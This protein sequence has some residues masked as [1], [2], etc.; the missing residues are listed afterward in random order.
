[1]FLVLLLSGF[2]SL[3]AAAV[4][5]QF[6]F[7]NEAK[8]WTEAQSYCR[9]HYT[10]LATL[11]N[12]DDVNALT[13]LGSP[14]GSAWIG[15]YDAWA[16][17]DGTSYDPSSASW[18]IAEPNDAS[19]YCA[20]M[21]TDGSWCDVSCNSQTDKFVCY[22]PGDTYTLVNTA[23]T[24][25]EAQAFCRAT[26]TDLATAQSIAQNEKV[27]MAA[28]GE[29]VHIGLYRAR[30][31]SDGSDS[32]FRHWIS[33][34]PDGIEHCTAL[35]F[36]DSGQWIDDSCSNTKPFFCYAATVATLRLKV[37]ATAELS[38]AEI[39]ENILKPLR[40]ELIRYGL[41]NSTSLSLRE[42][43]QTNP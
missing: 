22:G 20:Q 43:Y 25:T 21:N 1:M 27:F 18:R 41:P 29:F 33:G 39:E 10:E 24:W 28:N 14:T 36:S 40:E 30:T 15:L 32:S 42:F 9:S 35:S 4:S 6:Y 23:K 7:V 37:E 17:S 34:Q 12:T 5:H 31:W 11:Y 13:Q 19:V 3:T 8:S 16:W 2:L 26:Y 38:R